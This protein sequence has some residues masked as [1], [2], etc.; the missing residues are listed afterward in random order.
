MR[1]PPRYVRNISSKMS[2]HIW[3]LLGRPCLC[4][5]FGVNP[6]IAFPNFTQFRDPELLEAP[7]LRIYWKFNYNVENNKMFHLELDKNTYKYRDL[8]QVL[9]NVMDNT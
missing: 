1:G 9:K 8:F 7:F 5:L 2:E 4:L 6:G 3:M